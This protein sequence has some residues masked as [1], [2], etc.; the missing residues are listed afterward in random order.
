MESSSSTK[1]VRG[2]SVEGLLGSI[3]SRLNSLNSL[4]S[5]L[6]SAYSP[7]MKSSEPALSSEKESDGYPAYAGDIVRCLID[8]DRQAEYLRARI[9]TMILQSDL[10]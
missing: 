5:E 6:Y 2:E 10:V 4:V 8:I 1:D 3:Q 7:A 9:N